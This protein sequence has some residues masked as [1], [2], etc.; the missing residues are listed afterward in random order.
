MN[1]YLID[2]NSYVY[3]AYYAIRGLTNSKGFPT[4]AIYGFTTMLLKIIREKKP[5]SIVVSFD[6]PEPT[7]RHRIFEAYKAQRPETPGDLIEQLPYIRKMVAALNI[8]VYEIP[9]YEADD[10]LGTLAKKAASHGAHV[11]IV[12]GDKDM[13]QIVND[14][15]KVYDPMKDKVFDEAYVREKY[16]V[17]PGRIPEYM[18]LTGDAIDNIPGIKGIGEK[19]ARE[20]LTEFKSLDELLDNA[21]RI[22][23]EKLRSLVSEYADTAR[24]SKRLATLD[25]EV[26]LDFHFEEHSLK[27]PD[28]TA[29]LSLC[30][31]LE[32]GS[33]MK[34]VPSVASKGG[35]CE[36]VL[37]RTRLQE[38]ISM[39]KD[40][41][42]FDTETTG[43]NP[44][45]ANLVGLSI[46]IEKDRSYY[47]PLAHAYPGVPE[48]L[49]KKEV[50]QDLRGVFEDKDIAKIGHNLKY[51]IMMLKKEGISVG[52]KLFDTMIASYLL[53]PNKQNHSLEEVALRTPL[54]QKKGFSG[55]PGQTSFLC[56]S[57]FGGGSPLCLSGRIREP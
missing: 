10:I 24:L 57:P 1:I 49:E 54:V 38:V 2:G 28:W 45:A 25:T 16:G 32:F 7:E 43:R 55:S 3:R 6:S 29:L 35:D 22:R 34:L 5:D 26:P 15:I 36:T 41:V 19:T 11:F 37:L 40:E 50:M 51:D 52:G 21:G 17:G 47:V 46:S 12:T 27:D 8:K 48:Q 13:L 23:K 9:G 20:L 39:I 4:N 56:R 42:S 30:K 14:Q 18:A 33:L 53:N 31:E 44:V